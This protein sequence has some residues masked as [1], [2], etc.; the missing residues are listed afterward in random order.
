MFCFFIEL[1]PSYAQMPLNLCKFFWLP[2]PVVGRPVVVP[3]RGHL[4]A[5]ALRW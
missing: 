3:F 5:Q 2:F 1:V 4:S